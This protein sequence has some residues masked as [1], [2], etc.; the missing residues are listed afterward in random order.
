MRELVAKVKIGQAG[1]NWGTFLKWMHGQ[2]VGMYKDGGVNF[3]TYDV[4]RFI[5]YQC[6]PA[7]EPIEDFD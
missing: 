7:N 4:D 5:R 3:Y 2:T 1:G 6:D